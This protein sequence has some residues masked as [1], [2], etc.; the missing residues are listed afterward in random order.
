M[1][2]DRLPRNSR[3]ARSADAAEFTLQE[4]RHE[5][6]VSQAQVGERMGI[7]QLAVSKTERSSDP[8]LSTLRRYVSAL[9]SAAGVFSELRLVAVIGSDTYRLTLFEKDTMD[10]IESETTAKQSRSHAYRLRAWDDPVLE[11]AFLERS[12]IAM[13]DDEIGDLTQ[14]PGEGEVHTLLRDAPSLRGRSAQAIRTFTRYWSLFRVE[15]QRGDLVVVPMS[16]RR[17]AIA[18]VTGDYRYDP[19]EVN[20]RLR[21]QRSVEW[22]PVMSRD[23]LPDDIRK[24]VNAPGTIC[25]ISAVDAADRLTTLGSRG[26]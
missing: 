21:H 24:V 25:R 3:R 7:G 12:I 8:Q 19:S 23:D 18:R 15:M 6:N 20:T 9:G 22:F 1:L 2:R 16:S 11:H 14:W 13:S 4:L 10:V 26:E 17:A 5:L